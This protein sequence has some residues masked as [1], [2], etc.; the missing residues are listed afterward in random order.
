MYRWFNIS[1]DIFGRTSTD[2]QT[3]ISQDIFTKLN[4]NGYVK[5]DFTNQLF[6]QKHDAF[7][8]DR[9]V[10]GDCP[11]CLQPGARGDQCDYCGGLR[12]PL[13]LVNPRCTFDGAKPVVRL[14][15]QMFL[16]LNKL[17]PEI[18]KFTEESGAKGNWSPNGQSI[19]N[20]WIKKGLQPISITRDLVWGTKVPLS[21][22]K[23]RSC[24]LGSMH[25]SGTS[26]SR[27]HIPTSGRDGG[28]TLKM[29]S[30]TNSLAR[31]MSFFIL[32]S[33]QAR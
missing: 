13:D 17:Q 3:Q 16:E 8:S 27:L 32:S 6:C 23:T 19:T 14:T 22:T 24:I 4:A 30:C 25:A 9:F 33:F 2:L 7:L 26:Q 21:D 18:Q 28:E 15:K 12:D 11:E 31:T 20:A 5:G 10:E 1:F 29:Y